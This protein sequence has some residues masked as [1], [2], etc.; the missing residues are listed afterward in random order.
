MKNAI[1]FSK[2]LLMFLL[3]VF[4]ISCDG[5]DGMDGVDG[6]NGTAGPAGVNGEDGNANV[7]TYVYDLSSE[8]GS[9]IPVDLPELTQDV[10]DNDLIIGYLQNGA[11]SGTYYP[12]PASV[13][14]NGTGG[15]YDVAS[16][17][18]V[19]KYW[20]H[21]YQVGT[22]TFMDVTS[23]ELGKLKIV[24]AASTNTTTGKS[25]KE[26]IRESLKSAGVDINDYYAV[27]DYFGL[28]Y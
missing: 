28:E 2:H 24:I 6:I 5:K 15:F 21:F 13:W 23:V 14:P 10:I 3:T 1:K 12:V 27:M 20:V 22:Q 17:I 7:N 16:D 8:S 25:G 9:S 18:A 11:G 19:G 26:S 4:I